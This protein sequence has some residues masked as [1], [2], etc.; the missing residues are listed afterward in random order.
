MKNLILI[1]SLFISLQ[2]MSQAI[3]KNVGVLSGGVPTLTINT[4]QAL[5]DYNANLFQASGIAGNFASIQLLVTPDGNYLLV[6]TGASYKS[7]FFV[8]AVGKDLMASTG[9]SCTTSAC[10]QETFGCIPKYDEHPDNGRCTPCANDGLCTKV[11][12]SAALF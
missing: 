12:S 10:S 5:A 6:F 7:S 2:G 11:S 9:T 8:K 1:I 4:T 3:W